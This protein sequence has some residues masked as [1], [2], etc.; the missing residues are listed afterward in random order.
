MFD[1]RLLVNYAVWLVRQAFSLRDRLNRYLGRRLAALP[2]ATV[3]DRVAVRL[4]NVTALQ[5]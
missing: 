3:S 2:Q 5:M 1:V 4:R